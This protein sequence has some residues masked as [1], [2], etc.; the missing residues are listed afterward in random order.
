MKYIWLLAITSSKEG[1]IEPPPH[2]LGSVP[3]YI[4]FKEREPAIICIVR[5]NRYEKA[6]I[7]RGKF[8]S[9]FTGD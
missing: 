5:W 6:I 2:S 3:D 9:I 7:Q 8:F 1:G 4:V